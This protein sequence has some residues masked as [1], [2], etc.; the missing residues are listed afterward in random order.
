MNKLK[1]IGLSALAGSMVLTSA[2]AV[3]YT[4]T[5]DAAASYTGEHSNT[6]IGGEGVALDTSI[7]LNAAGS[8]DNGWDVGYVLNLDNATGAVANTSAQGAVTMGSMGTVQI[9]QIGGSAVNAI[10]DVTP[11][12]WEEVYGM[13]TLTTG[14]ATNLAGGDAG[15]FGSSVNSGSI[16]YTTPAIDMMGTTV[17]ASLVFD[18]NANIGSTAHKGING[19]ETG[20]GYVVKM[21]H[22]S[23]LSIGAGMEEI[24]S[25]GLTGVTAGRQ[26][27]DETSVTVYGKYAYGPVSLG[28]QE[29]YQDTLDGGRDLE[30]E[31]YSVAY[32]SGD[33]SVSFGETEVTTK[34]L[35][36]TGSQITD[37]D[38]IAVS[39]TMGSMTIQLQRSEQTRATKTTPTAVPT[40]VTLDE[41]GI[42][43]GFAF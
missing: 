23:G 17:S 15:F 33:V 20:M 34:G 10:D 8:L 41:T 40:N 38:A 16:Q 29:S 27:N 6:S 5:G 7:Y 30:A 21:A 4:V 36:S 32:T 24:D 37:G 31:M 26:S 19:G 11:S 1:T 25:D 39:Y 42:K 12:A 28:Y 13:G 35:G 2:N 3:D 18:P 14:T 43:V 22:E 9:N